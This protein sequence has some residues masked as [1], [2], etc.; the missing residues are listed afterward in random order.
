MEAILG[1]FIAA[2]LGAWGHC[3]GMC[4]GI[5]LGLNTAKSIDNTKTRIALGNFVYFLGRLTSYIIV[6]IIF[7]LIGK[8]FIDNFHRGIVFIVI[9][10]LIIITAL[11][12]NFYP[13]ALGYITP[14]ANSS[15]YKRAF[16]YALQSK[17]FY[18]YYVLGVLNGFLPCGFVYTFALVAAGFNSI[19]M[20][21]LGMIAFGIGTFLP[22]FLLGT[23]LGSLIR[24]GF[25][26]RFST[27]LLRISML[28]MLYFGLG[29]IFMGYGM[30]TGHM[31]MLPGMHMGMKGMHGM[32]GMGGMDMGHGMHGMKMQDMKMDGMKMDHGHM[33]MDDMKGSTHQDMD[34][35]SH[36]MGNMESVHM[37]SKDGMKDMDMHKD[38]QNMQNMKDMSPN[39]THM[40]MQNM[41]DMKMDSKD[42]MKGMHMDHNSHNADMK[43]M[44]MKNMHDMHMDSK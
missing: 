31:Y 32:H 27:W 4:G 13:K 17:S 8:S 33:N 10:V 9:G 20:S 41:G 36:N 37:D 26:A 3:V 23:S 38:M 22:L 24:G 34:M 39:S 28:L 43:N 7:A 5:V 19:P 15:W 35:K 6:G 11:L 18:S 1:I 42:G 12:F 40:D 16:K 2:F 21:I 30:M 25:R 29:N 14:S 44:D